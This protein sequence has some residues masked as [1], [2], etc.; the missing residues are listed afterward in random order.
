LSDFTTLEALLHKGP[1]LVSELGRL[2]QLTSGAITT[3]IDRLESQRLVERSS[4]TSDRRARVV[5]L[6]GDG[7]ALISKIFGQHSANL[8]AASGGLTNAERQ[9]LIALLKS[10]ARP[11]R[12]GCKPLRPPHK[13][14][15]ADLRIARH[16]R[17]SSMATGRQQRP[18]RSPWRARRRWRRSPVVVESDG[19]APPCA[20]RALEE[21]LVPRRLS[22]ALVDTKG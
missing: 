21:A 6:T 17:T 11:P 1:L 4:D 13:D 22:L 3:A 5:T 15:A 19:H 12:K 16:R 8:D 18:A 9:R 7:R 2:V 20:R 14:R 10:W